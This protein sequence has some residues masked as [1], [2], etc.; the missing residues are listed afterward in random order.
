MVAIVFIRS[1][2]A[3]V[4]CNVRAQNYLSLTGRGSSRSGL[5]S[6]LAFFGG[7]GGKCEGRGVT[8]CPLCPQ[9]T[10][11][12]NFFTYI[13]Y[14]QQGLV[15]QDG[16]RPLV[17]AWGG[18]R[19]GKGGAGRGGRA[20]PRALLHPVGGGLCEREG[21]RLAKRSGSSCC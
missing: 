18:A 15:R 14:I 5:R 11:V 12:C 7:G 16:E 2:S 13:R 3:A 8:P 9:I 10:A 19:E 1:T 17:A 6:T 21:R 20:N 4:D